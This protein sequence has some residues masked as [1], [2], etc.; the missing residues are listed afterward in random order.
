MPTCSI[1][2]GLVTYAVYSLQCSVFYKCVYEIR[3]LAKAKVLYIASFQY[4]IKLVNTC[5]INE[6]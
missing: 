1:I 4:I 2:A 5:I 6:F 3:K